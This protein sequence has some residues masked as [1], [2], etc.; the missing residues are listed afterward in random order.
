MT[1]EDIQITRAFIVMGVMAI[2]YFGWA[3]LDKIN[4]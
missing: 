3:I 1:L 2:A 4:K